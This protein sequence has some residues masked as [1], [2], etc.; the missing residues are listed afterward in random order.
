MIKS[1]LVHRIASAN[2]HLYVREIEKIVGAIFD[3]ISNA[4]ARGDRVELRG[5]GTFSLRIRKARI[6][7]DP[8]TGGTVSVREKALPY[9][10]AG[11]E[12]NSR[13]NGEQRLP[14]NPSPSTSK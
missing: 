7:R 6:G 9:F 5:F 11:K 4:M 8:R 2:T 10:R 1:E 3:E 13:L 14:T 12:M